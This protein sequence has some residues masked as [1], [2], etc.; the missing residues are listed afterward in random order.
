MQTLATRRC[1]GTWAAL[2]AAMVALGPAAHAETAAE[3]AAAWGLLGTWSLDCR[4]PP[5]E[6]NS[7]MSYVVMPGGRLAHER[8]FGGRRD[9]N[10]VLRAMLGVG[11][12]DL[13]VYFPASAQTRQITLARSP[14]GRVRAIADSLLSSNE[15]AIWDGRFIATG[16]ETPW[17][18]R[19]R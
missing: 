2:L 4:L 13:T 12:I 3:T 18:V 11:G 17:Q 1:A 10:E 6:G 9:A 8:D 5:S 14:D 19:C 7:Y 16:T 15:F